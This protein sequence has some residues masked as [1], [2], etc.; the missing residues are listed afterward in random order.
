MG[1]TPVSE[2]DQVVAE[3]EAARDKQLRGRAIY[4]E[5]KIAAAV[6]TDTAIS[7]GKIDHPYKGKDGGEMLPSYR[8]QWAAENVAIRAACQQEID[9]WAVRND[10]FEGDPERMVAVLIRDL[11][12]TAA[13]V[14]VS[15]NRCHANGLDSAQTSTGQ[16]IDVPAYIA[17]FSPVGIPDG[18]AVPVPVEE[19][20]A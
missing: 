3:R 12:R 10:A 18:E 1:N 6:N 4:W 15:L 5:A 13:A 9:Q 8:S 19:A 11:E 7:L 16:V 17:L 14:L 20:A 2:F